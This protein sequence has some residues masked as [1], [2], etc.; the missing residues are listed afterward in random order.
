MQKCSAS[1]ILLM[2]ALGNSTCRGCE[3]IFPLTQLLGGASF[4]G[5]MLLT[6]SLVLLAIAV[7]IKC[8]VFVWLDRRLPWRKAVLFMLL[9]NVLSTIPGV[10]IAAFTASI[11]GIV[12]ALPLVFALGWM[13]QRRIA[14]LPEAHQWKRISGGG[15]LIA[16]IAFFIVSV[17]LYGVAESVLDARNYQVYWIL[18]FIFVTLVACTG[19]VMSAVLEECV[20]A[21]L[22]RKSS[23][24]LS[25]FTPVFRAN[26]ITLGVILLVAAVKMLPQRLHSPHFITGWFNAIL[27]AVGL[28]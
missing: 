1:L 20:V 5:P 17:V 25:F 28:A 22:T 21:F 6:R 15:A 27:T 8:F 24:N 23:S 18:K 7:A 12:L 10:L 3:P 11:V 26:Y 2:A 13:V 16:F 9:A 19:I 14:R 4:A